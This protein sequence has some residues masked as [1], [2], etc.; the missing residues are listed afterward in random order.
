MIHI[1]GCKI[2]FYTNVFRKWDNL[3]VRGYDNGKAFSEE[4]KYEPYLFVPSDKN[5]GYNT[6]K[7][8]DVRR[9]D[10]TSMSEAS[11]YVKKHEGLI[12]K[13]IYG[14]TDY[15]YVYL[16]DNYKEGFEYDFNL[17]KIVSLDIETDSSDGFPN[18]AE[19][20][21]EITAITLVLKGKTI[22]LGY[23]DYDPKL[24]N[25]KYIKCDNEI[26]L[27][28]NFIKIWNSREWSPDIITGW[29]CIPL[30]QSVWGTNKITSIQNCDDEILDS[31]IIR[32]SPIN[33][34]RKYEINLVN[35]GKISSSL[36]HKFPVV[37]C[38]SKKYTKLNLN[39]NKNISREVDMSVEQMKETKD[40]LFLKIPKHE[41]KNV[42]NI[43]YS[44]EELYLAGL[45]YTDGTIKDIKHPEW[46][47]TFFQ[48]D[49]MLMKSLTELGINSNISGPDK[50][51]CYTRYINPSFLGKT[52][53]LIYSNGKKTINLEKLSTLSHI[54][55]KYF[56]SGLVD[57]DGYIDN[58]KIG[59]CNYNENDI[60][61]I[62]ELCLWNNM[63]C[64][65]SK[66]KLRMYF[67]IENL[68]TRKNIRWCKNENNKVN[69]LKRNSSQKSSDI[70]FKEFE[71]FY[72]VR[73][74]NIID[75]KEDVD[76]MD[77]ETDTHYFVSSGIKTHNCEFFDIPYIVNRIRK[78]L[79]ESYI[80]KLSPFGSVKERLVNWKN[81][82]TFTTYDIGGISSVDYLAAYK[83]FSMSEK[84]SYKLDYICL[85][86]IDEQKL[87]YS[88]YKTL[89]RLYKE[90]FELFMDYNIHDALLVEKLEEKLHFIEQMVSIAYVQRV[91][92][93]DTI[94]TV[95]PWDII[96][97]NY[98][99][100]QNIVIPPKEME[101]DNKKVVGG[102]VK[103]PVPGLYKWV[104]SVDFTSL[105][106]SLAMQ[107][108]ISPDT[109]REL[110][111]GVPSLEKIMFGD[112][113]ELTEKLK[114]NDLCM[115]PN[116]CFYK[117]DKRGFFP[118]ILKKFFDGRKVYKKQ[119]IKAKQEYQNDPSDI[120]RN[121]Y[122]GLN[123]L[124]TAFKLIGNSGYGAMLNKFF[125][126]YASY[127]GESITLS[128][129][130]TTMYI[131]N[132][133]N[134]HLNKLF[135]TIDQDYVIYSDTDS[136]YINL[137]IVVNKLGLKDNEKILKIL[138]KVMEETIVPFINNA[139]IELGERLNVY[140]IT[141]NVKLEKICDKVIF[142][143]KKRY[144]LSVLYDEG[145]YYKEPEIKVTGMETVRSSTPFISRKQLEECFKI[146]MGKDNAAL[147]DLIKEFKKDFEKLSFID[148]GKPSGVNGIKKY[149]DP[150]S[151]YKKGTP[152][153]VRGALVFNKA[154]AQKGLMD[155]FEMIQDHDKIKFCY[156]KVPNPF[157]EDVICV[158]EEIPEILGIDKFIDY[159]K[160]FEVVFLK[161][162]RDLCDIIH[163]KTE[164]Y[165]TL[166]DIFG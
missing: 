102:Y 76:M 82:K 36:E 23:F 6:I 131:T 18:I 112:I 43:N 145:V 37:I 142:K 125:R 164:D 57:G 148:I 8:E 119:M 105:Y 106:P 3:F 69:Y 149:Y 115:T 141:T 19:A 81:G 163:W 30:N 136:A 54:Q 13:K 151:L 159:D 46:G 10:F 150:Y 86:E 114:A 62:Y 5:T 110:W 123:N 42:T 133:L 154:I 16:Y 41:N 161:P 47:Y 127:L 94:T 31:K 74:S 130:M 29:N 44:N 93:E 89:D 61:K 109:F 121:K 97:H 25:R 132:K 144:V 98:L 95:K 100:D 111:E 51:G 32:R 28:K 12:G 66:N 158:K 101:D 91:N 108:N 73:V 88:Q 35:G 58:G 67:E 63:F 103:E 143:G 48:S 26:Q 39:G 2:R 129:Q 56:F 34:K 126:W 166:D 146:I 134:A 120:N 104:A 153:H 113:S 38:D 45:I 139:C 72:L 60:E 4:I 107:Y 50:K 49:Y 128:G 135:G 64:Q 157:H 7:G 78:I 84:E 155:K 152:I 59:F 70:K 140:E 71:D 27:L 11:N 96:I 68:P 77:I 138:V 80:K 55:F 122:N 83:K 75:T 165:N 85:V 162:L 156:L 40:T 9:I 87:D 1:R 52:H 117:R 33:K 17:I 22:S 65:I 15:S 24:P 116:G 118:S 90:N 147:L 14:L 79:G 21:K 99:M 20:N 160:Q 92:F 53:E 137:E 124:Q